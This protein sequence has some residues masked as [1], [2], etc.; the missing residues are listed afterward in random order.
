M[1]PPTKHRSA[2]SASE[3]PEAAVRLL[4]AAEEL[5]AERGFAATS[6]RDLAE[7]AGVNVA[8][9]NYY[10]GDKD[11]LY[12]ETLRRAFR[13]QRASDPGFETILE[14][15][16]REGTPAAAA[17][18]LRRFIELYMDWL[19]GEESEKAGTCTCALFQREMNDPTPALDVIVEEFIEPKAEV[20]CDLLQQARPELGT[21][22]EKL[23]LHAA[24]IVGQC[25]H[26]RFALP[27][28][29]R[30]HKKEKFSEENIRRIADHIATF[31]LRGLGLEEAAE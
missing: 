16:R 5:F 25:L 11:S 24:S 21:N 1:V 18:G 2:A 28:I 22:K 9:V 30:L 13:D 12:V 31:T 7:A 19:F 10:F 20:L 14:E 29:L 3:R 4:E 15:A 17:R 23:L 6:V 27:V 26:Y 8:A